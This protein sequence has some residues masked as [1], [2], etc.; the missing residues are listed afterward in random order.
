MN[1]GKL[2]GTFWPPFW[3]P[4]W[5]KRPS[6]RG[7][8]TRPKKRCEKTNSADCFGAARRN[9]RALGEDLGGVQKHPRAGKFWPRA[10]GKSSARAGLGKALGTGNLARH[11]CKQGRRIAAAHSARPT[12]ESWDGWHVGKCEV[13]QKT[14]RRKGSQ[15]KTGRREGQREHFQPHLWALFLGYGGPGAVFLAPLGVRGGG[16]GPILDHQG[17]LGSLLFGSFGNSGAHVGPQQ[18]PKRALERPRV[19]F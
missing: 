11:P 15:E 17:V 4:K 18:R 2:F 19:A 10:L 3:E 14:E 5:A 12:W 7:P 9:A 13:N 6:K 8:K 16:L 1:F